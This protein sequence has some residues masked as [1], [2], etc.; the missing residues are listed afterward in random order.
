[1]ISDDKLY[2]AEE[3]EEEEE[4]LGKVTKSLPL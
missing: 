2:Y 1:V 3:Y 4:D